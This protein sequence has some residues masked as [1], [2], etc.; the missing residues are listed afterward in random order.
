MRH[1]GSRTVARLVHGLALVG[2]AA[3]VAMM[4][5][6]VADVSLRSLFDRTIP[7]TIEYVSFWLMLP[8]AFAGFSLA[9][10]R[11]DHI[12]VPLVVDRMPS[13]VR[14]ACVIFSDLLLLA[15]AVALFWYGVFSAL[16]RLANGETTGASGINIAP[17]RL[18]VPVAMAVLALQVADDLISTITRRKAGDDRAE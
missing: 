18:V 8:M 9:K 6:V 3:V 11:R 2:S 15:F 7:G 4:L 17:T 10:R 16:D 14:R 13:E 1:T 12:D 5:L